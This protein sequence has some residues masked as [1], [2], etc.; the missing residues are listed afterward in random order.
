MERQRVWLIFLGLMTAG[1]AVQA[2]QRALA[3]P[4]QATRPPRAELRLTGHVVQIYAP[5]VFTVREGAGAE[6]ELLVLTPRA[7]KLFVGATVTVEGVLRRLNEADL[8]QVVGVSGIDEPTRERLTRGPVLVATSVLA[9]SRSEPS[10]TVEQATPNQLMETPTPVLRRSSSEERPVTMRTAML[11]ANLD[12]FAGRQVRLLNGRLVGVLEPGAFLIEPATPYLKA[13]GQRGRV[14]V[15]LQ[16][17][18]LRV[19]AELIVGSTVTVTGV[20][21]TLVGMQVT[22]E[23]AWPARLQRNVADRLEVRAAVLATSVQTEDGVELSDRASTG[24]R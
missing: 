10:P 1:A 24:A 12:V 16:S 17:A 11:V 8:K 13:M 23:V 4:Q 21:R 20:A 3:A 18:A 14:I 7:L 22:R 5:R 6:R 19:P 15:L 9:L 2:E